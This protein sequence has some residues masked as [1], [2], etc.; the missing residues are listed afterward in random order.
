MPAP[1]ILSET[2][3]PPTHAVLELT[4]NDHPGV[5]AHVCGLFSRRAFNVEGILCLPV[6]GGRSRIWLRVANDHRLKQTVRQLSKLHDVREVRRH[7]ADHQVFLRL[8]ALFQKG[9]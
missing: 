5:M 3:V 7:E 8:E 4:V 6:G 2:P 1:E 9:A